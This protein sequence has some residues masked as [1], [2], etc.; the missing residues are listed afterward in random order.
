VIF[1]E[2]WQ[3]LQEKEVGQLLDIIA[4]IYAVVAQ[5]VAESPEFTYDVGH[6]PSIL[7]GFTGLTG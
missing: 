7:T 1:I 4:V 5:G 6:I 3:K 2:E